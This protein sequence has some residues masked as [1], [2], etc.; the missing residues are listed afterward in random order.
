[1][2]FLYVCRPG[3]LSDNRLLLLWTKAVVILDWGNRILDITTAGIGGILCCLC[4]FGYCIVLTLAVL[5]DGRWKL[6]ATYCNPMRCHHMAWCSRQ[7]QDVLH[8]AECPPAAQQTSEWQWTESVFTV[9]HCTGSYNSL[10]AEDW[11]RQLNLSITL[12]KLKF[13]PVR[14]TYNSGSWW[15]WF[16]HFT[17]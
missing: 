3:E 7:T 2:L 8:P 10:C 1:M 5:T 17:Y 6:I 16:L 14:A 4:G 13:F 15:M 11:F 12:H 9:S